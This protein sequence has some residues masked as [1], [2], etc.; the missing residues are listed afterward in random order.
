MKSYGT[1]GRELLDTTGASTF[2]PPNDIMHE[3]LMFRGQDIKDLHVH[4][5]QTTKEE[6]EVEAPKKEEKKQ[7]APAPPQAVAK[8][9]AAKPSVKKA[10]EKKA[11]P[12]KKQ[13]PP[14]QK[15]PEAPKIVNYASKVK[16]GAQ[17]QQGQEN[18][19]PQKKTSQGGNKGK[20]QNMVGT[21]ASLMNRKV[22]GA[23][24]DQG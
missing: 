21:G 5:N 20:S 9:P 14:P 2:V 12:Q 7:P 23:K 10:P 1:E 15:K 13:Q 24:G 22:R 6:E 19:K 8:A 11:P 17:L 4:E 16:D 3:F 18:N